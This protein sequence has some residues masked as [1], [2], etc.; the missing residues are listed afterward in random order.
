MHVIY[1]WNSLYVKNKS[2]IFLIGGV[3]LIISAC[4]LTFLQI[5]AKTQ[6]LLSVLTDENR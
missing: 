5:Q 6:P 2:V 1:M 3:L 4:M